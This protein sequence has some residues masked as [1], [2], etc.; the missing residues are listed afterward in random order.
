MANTPHFPFQIYCKQIEVLFKKAK[1]NS[2]PAMFL[3][4]N[5]ARMS[6]FMAESIL[7]VSNKL[8]EDKEIKDWHATIKKLE[9]YLG[10]LDHYLV[11]LAN[12]SKLKTIHI[13]QLEYISKKLEKTIDKLNSKL[14][15]H[16]FYLEDLKKMGA[17]FKINFNDKNL[18]LKLHEE[19]RSELKESC[20]FFDQYPKEFDD[21]E[22]QVHELRRKLRW[23]SIYGESF[24]GLIV[25]K[26]VKEKYNWEKE[27]ITANELKNPFNKLPV[28]KNLVDHI[29]LNKKA[30]YALSYVIDNLGKIKDKGLALEV[31]EKSIRK[32]NTEK[33]INSAI[34]ASK[35]LNAKYTHASL[36]KEAHSLLKT[37][38]KKH[39]LHEI[40]A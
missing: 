5:K 7:R 32:T 24:Q 20:D 19:I 25:L 31:L 11:L 33:G 1:T 6:L 21:M 35:Q 29:D 17:G 9:D 10:E 12:F 4:K 2:N 36:L 27:F 30:F 14:Q 26:D 13:Q 15:K 23:I 37:Y 22:E 18:I 38:Y 34:L 8:F 40:L 28:K 16:D 3:Y 39:K